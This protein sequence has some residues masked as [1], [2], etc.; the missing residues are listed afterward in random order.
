MIREQVPMLQVRVKLDL[1]DGRRHGGGRQD[2]IEVRRKVVA[3]ADA[4]RLA[5]RLDGFHL[6]PLGLQLLGVV[7]A[8]GEEG[9]VD[10]VQIHVVEAELLQRGGET[11]LDRAFGAWDVRALCHDVEL[12]PGHAGLLDGFAEFLLIAVTVGAVQMEVALWQ[13]VS[14][15]LNRSGGR[16]RVIRI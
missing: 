1:V 2:G 9:R 7:A 6:S 5:R 3:D 16:R 8:V 11:R 4:A 12:L 14:C 15:W 10:K 13:W